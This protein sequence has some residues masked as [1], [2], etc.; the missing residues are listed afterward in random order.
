MLA[1]ADMEKGTR[2]MTQENILARYKILHELG[3][4]A[5]GAVYAARDR[6]TGAV[7]ALKRIDPALLSKS[8]ANS[9]G[10]FLQHA[11]SARLLQHGNIV[12]IHNA[13]EVGGTVYVAMEMLEGRSLR[14]ILD[15]GPLP[16]AR[17]IRI[18]HDIA[19]GLAHAHLEG[20]V[21]GA[22]KPANV[23]VLGSGDVKITDFGIGQAAPL[24]M[25][26]EQGRGE[27]VDHRGDIFSLGALFYEMLAHRPPFE[28][29]SPKEITQN[30]VRAKPPPPSEL[31][32]H[33]PRALDAIVFSMLAGEPAARMPGVPV[34]LRELQRLEEG[35]GLG[36]G[37][38]AGTDEPT[39]SVPPAAPGPGLRTPEAFDFHKAMIMMERESRTERPSGSRPG[40]F[41]ALALVL[42]VLGIGVAG[43][44]YYSSEAPATATEA[45]RPAAPAPVAEATKESVTA[46]AA[47]AQELP[48]VMQPTPKV[49][50]QQPAGTARLILAVSPRGEIYIDGKHH[51]T[52]PPITTFDLEPGMHRIEVR[53]GSRKP[54][55]TYVTVQARDVRRIRHDFDAKPSGP[56]RRNRG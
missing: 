52:T 55:L 7:V 9:A 46:F 2:D 53:S 10:R 54:Y 37:A 42:A 3:R 28:G 30:I 24:S 35:L 11:R 14:N 33:V 40:I 27:P 32:Q 6:E 47:P 16:I 1:R 34:L 15:A 39:A 8:G 41:A 18:A 21:H 31:N 50:E 56:T 48:P 17:A 20:V 51:G 22:I 13:G 26:P 29:G 45:S 44:L 49:A 4:G 38:N 5:T 23:I 12:K 36:S 25:S 19:C 43:F